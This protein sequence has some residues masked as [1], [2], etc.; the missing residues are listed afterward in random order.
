LAHLELI[1]TSVVYVEQMALITGLSELFARDEIKK[2]MQKG[3]FN[4]VREAF[5]KYVS[6]ID[7]GRLGVPPNAVYSQ[8]N[9][10]RAQISCLTASR[11][12]ARARTIG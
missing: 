7:S 8:I 2:N 3:Y 9:K 1:L 4:D 5:L 11:R 12:Q 10:A 6:K